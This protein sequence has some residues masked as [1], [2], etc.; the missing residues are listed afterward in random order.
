[1]DKVFFTDLQL[2]HK[3]QN[4]DRKGFDELFLR[5]HKSL[6]RI[7]K[8][9]MKDWGSAEDVVQETF[10]KAFLKLKYFRAE[11]SV[12]HWL[13]KIAINTAHNKL[14]QKKV[15]MNIQDCLYLSIEID[16][17]QIVMQKKWSAILKKLIAELPPKQQLSLS[18]RVYEDMD[19]ID[20]AKKMQCPYDTAKAN[21][22]HA[23]IK[24]KELLLAENFYSQSTVPLPK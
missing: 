7:S 20:I 10:L 18:L 4:G 6:L 8:R 21:Y 1:M 19:F 22:R 23:L 2:V 5:H 17:E 15:Q 12:Y 3:I 11:C 16:F 13:K 24:L 9:F 14:R